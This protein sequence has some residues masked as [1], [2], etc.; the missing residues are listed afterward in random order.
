M[1]FHRCILPVGFVLA[2]LACTPGQRQAART[3]LDLLDDNCLIINQALPDEVAFLECKVPTEPE[4]R[5]KAKQILSSSRTAS[6]QAVAGA[7]MAG[8]CAPPT[9][10]PAAPSGD[11]GAR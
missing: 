1:H 9:A 6:A 5:A 2:A 4:V 7:R 3:A 11:A 8:A 10:P